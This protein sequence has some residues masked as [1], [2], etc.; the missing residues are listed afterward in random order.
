MNPV[1]KEAMAVAIELK[2]VV[3]L[4]LCNEISREHFEQRRER[5]LR[6]FNSISARLMRCDELEG[7]F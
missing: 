5:L 1:Q 3:S 7:A 6:D 4:R 2:R